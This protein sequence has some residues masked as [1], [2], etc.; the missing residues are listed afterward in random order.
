MYP[1][2]KD[3]KENTI[4]EIVEKI[5]SKYDM[6]LETINNEKLIQ[7]FNNIWNEY[8]DDYFKILKKLFDV[9]IEESIVA[10]IGLLPVCPRF[11]NERIFYLNIYEFHRLILLMK[12]NELL[13]I[14]S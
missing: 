13:F 7:K 4:D 8:N 2:L 1:E 11:I 9:E 10:K 3:I 12:S 14:L 6:T 5:K